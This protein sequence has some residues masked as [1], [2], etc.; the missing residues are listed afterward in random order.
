M[1]DEGSDLWAL[2]AFREL[3]DVL[4]DLRFNRPEVGV[5]VLQTRGDAAR[6]LA[7][8]QA[9]L[10]QQGGLVRERGPAPHEA[11]AEAPGPH[12]ADASSP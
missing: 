7:A 3:D 9:L 6:V 12:G 8:D 2:R 4:L 10:R 5:V 11:R 1:R